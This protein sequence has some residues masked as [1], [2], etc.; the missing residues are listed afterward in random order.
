MLYTDDNLNDDFDIAL[1][2]LWR[3]VT[4]GGKQPE[5]LLSGL[6]D[7]LAIYLRT[8]IP[9][10]AWRVAQKHALRLLEEVSA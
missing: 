9:P 4:E 10:I 2:A 8:G 1:N 7:E 3:M 5:I 6:R